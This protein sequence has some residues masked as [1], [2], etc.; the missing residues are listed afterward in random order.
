MAWPDSG[1]ARG[2]RFQVANGLCDAGVADGA[3]LPV[4]RIRENGTLQK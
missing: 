2:A 1:P 4:G 3:D